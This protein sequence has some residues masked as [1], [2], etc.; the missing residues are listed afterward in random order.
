MGPLFLG[1]VL[2]LGFGMFSVFV[3][4]LASG[5][6]RLLPKSLFSWSKTFFDPA[7]DRRDSS[8]AIQR[9]WQKTF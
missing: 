2:G 3:V 1:G 6:N 8:P 5:L 7:K 4:R 9:D